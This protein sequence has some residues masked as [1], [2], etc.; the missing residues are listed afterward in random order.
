MTDMLFSEASERNKNPILEVLQQVLPRDGTVLEIGSGSGQ[1][2]VY[3]APQFPGLRWQP[4][5]RSENLPGLINRLESEG[6]KNI[7]PAIELDVLGQ[8]PTALFDL[9]YSANT[10]HIMSWDAVCATFA[11]LGEHLL[12]GG[13]YCLY[14]PFNQ[15]GKFTS[16]SNQEF[17]LQLGSR[18]PQ[19]GLRDE[20]ALESLAQS[21]QMVIQSRFSM[22]A[23]NFLL[24]FKKIG[25]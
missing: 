10:S 21:H 2:V 24:V 14:G 1:H 12:K 19:M 23:N 20:E 22:P 6:G 18:D 8:W 15:N 13:L 5:D 16:S 25:I 3:F 9:V 7:L 4:S 17:D 11:G